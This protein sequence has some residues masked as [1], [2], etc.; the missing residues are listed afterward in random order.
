MPHKVSRRSVLPG[1]GTL[2]AAA[3][4]SFTNSALAAEEDPIHDPVPRCKAAE[5]ETNWLAD[6][7]DDILK[8]I[9]QDVRRWTVDE[10]AA[11]GLKADRP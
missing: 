3:A 5:G 6:A 7:A 11:Y 10:L 1:T 8:A 2:A 9:P 4:L